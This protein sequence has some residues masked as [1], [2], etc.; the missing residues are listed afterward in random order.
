MPSKQGVLFVVVIFLFLVDIYFLSCLLS[1]RVVWHQQLPTIQSLNST[2]RKCLDCRETLSQRFTST[3]G[4]FGKRFRRGISRQLD[5]SGVGLF[6]YFFLTLA[7]VFLVIILSVAFRPG[8]ANRNV[9]QIFARVLQDIQQLME[10]DEAEFR[11]IAA[12][13]RQIVPVAAGGPVPAILYQNEAD[14]NT[15]SF[16]GKLGASLSHLIIPV[17]VANK[18]TQPAAVNLLKRKGEPE[19]KHHP[20]PAKEHYSTPIPINKILHSILNRYPSPVQEELTSAS[21]DINLAGYGSSFLSWLV[22]HPTTTTTSTTTTTTTTTLR[23]HYH[24]PMLSP[25]AEITAALLDA[26]LYNMHSIK[27]PQPSPPLPSPYAPNPYT[28]PPLPSPN[29]TAAPVVDLVSTTEDLAETLISVLMNPLPEGVYPSYKPVKSSTIRPHA[30]A[31]PVDPWPPKKYRPPYTTTS[32]QHPTT[33]PTKYKPPTTSYRPSSSTRP[34]PTTTTSYKPSSSS[35][36]P[37]PSST[38]Y[39]PSSYKPYRPSY[40]PHTTYSSFISST[41]KPHRPW[42]PPHRPQ[43][44]I[45]HPSTAKPYRP[46]WTT[47]AYGT[48][49]EWMFGPVYTTSP[50]SYQVSK[51]VYHY[52]R[53]PPKT[54]PTTRPTTTRPPWKYGPVYTSTYSPLHFSSLE[55]TAYYTPQKNVHYPHS[56]G[57][58]KPWHR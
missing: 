16:L 36:R 43:T 55:V 54:K 53:P 32:T 8:A 19:K 11:E 41:P 20:P 24:K 34:K 33:K 46:H 5:S 25:S 13:D 35:Y 4:R 50:P 28:L 29:T 6:S 7:F 21:E 56:V 30:T 42:F 45:Y 22:N 17:L 12:E 37:K 51:P 18:N 31:S 15:N 38:S 27:L 10:S 52:Y 48:R 23:P 1:T 2:E 39:R 14:K 44:T 49:P 47:I 26:A 40:K 57:H 3:S 9:S 58:Y